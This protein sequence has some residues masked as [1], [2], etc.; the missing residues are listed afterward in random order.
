[1]STFHFPQWTNHFK[2]LIPAA[3]IGGVLY[4]AVFIYFG[5]SPKTIAVGYKPTQPVPF[6]HLLHAGEL[7]MDCR[8]CH[9]TVE[10]AAHAAIPPTATC[11][12]CHAAIHTDS[13]KLAPVRESWE[14]GK[15]VEWVR[16][17]DLPDYAYFNHSAHVRRG[18]S[19]V[20]CH[21]RIDQ[22]EVVSQQEPLNMGWCLEC[23]RNPEPHLRPLNQITNL[24]WTPPE[25]DD[26]WKEELF[27]SAEEINPQETC[28]TCHR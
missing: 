4:A 21:G 24:G 3:A 14:T 2:L 20:S 9:N 8:Y 7:G 12:N 28:S 15:P 1:M 13:T 6:S 16:V 25:G 27:Y 17:H 19:C 11:M 26:S 22:M 18:V 5:L 23:H 10:E